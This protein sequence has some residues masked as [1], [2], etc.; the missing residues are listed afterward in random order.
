VDVIFNGVELPVS[1]ERCAE[2]VTEKID[3]PRVAARIL[4]VEDD[5]TTGETMSHR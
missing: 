4:A 1:D 2:A 3:K 5:R